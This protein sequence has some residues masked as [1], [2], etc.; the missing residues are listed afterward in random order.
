[1]C[2]PLAT[3]V[4]KH[5]EIPKLEDIPIIQEFFD[6]FQAELLTIT[7]DKKI[8]FVIGLVSGTMSISKAPYRM[9]PAELGELQAQLQDLFEKDFIKPTMHGLS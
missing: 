5:R 3:V 1:M 6:A 4:E 2:S 7:L 8:E 9:A